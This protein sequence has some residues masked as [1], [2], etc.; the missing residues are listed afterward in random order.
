M[1]T[2]NGRVAAGVKGRLGTVGPLQEVPGTL[3]W[4]GDRNLDEFFE[5]YRFCENRVAQIAV[6]RDLWDAVRR[7]A[8]SVRRVIVTRDSRRPLD[9]HALREL[10]RAYPSACFLELMGPLCA[11]GVTKVA[12]GQPFH[13][14]WHQANQ[15]LPGWLQADDGGRDAPWGRCGAGHGR[16]DRGVSPRE[17]GDSVASSVAVVAA[18]AANAEPLMDLA[19]SVGKVA[20]WCRHPDSFRLRNVDVVWWDDS[21]TGRMGG[22]EWHRRMGAM[23]SANMS[24]PQRHAWLVTAPNIEHCRTAYD[25][26]VELILTKPARIEPLLEMLASRARG[27]RLAATIEAAA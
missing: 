10:R 24:G 11:D 6:R 14:H 15:V 17:D 12:P 21:A 2:D 5:A 16:S 9:D 20:V 26:G 4:V 8:S 23:R 22:D 1:T 3:I 25:A 27:W 19:A 18:V 13:I 7:P